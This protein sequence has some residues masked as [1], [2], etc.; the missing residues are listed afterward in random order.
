MSEKA[1]R[2][3]EISRKYGDPWIWGIYITLV[4]L[5]IV[6]SYSAS[7]RE[8]AQHGIYEP[9]IKQVVFLGIGAS[10][11]AVLHRIN[12][13]NKLVMLVLIPLLWIFTVGSL[14]YVMVAGD[15]INGARRSFTIMGQ[16]VQPA[17]LA[18]LSAVTMLAYVMARNQRKMDVTNTGVIISAAVAAI[19]GGLTYVSGATNAIIIMS[20]SL[21]MMVVGGCTLKKLGIVL[22]VYGMVFGAYKLIGNANEQREANLAQ[23]RIEA[24]ASTTTADNGT[25]ERVVDRG[26]MREGRLEN[27][28]KHD[29]LLYKPITPYNQQEMFSMMAQAHGGILGTGIGN[30]RE[31]S[32][33]P[34]A[35]S[36]YIFSIIIEEM[37]LVG[38]IFVMILYLWLLARAAMIAR[39]CHRV[40]PALLIIGM[41]SMITFQ[42]L[43][44]MAINTGVFP[45]SGQPLPLVSKG[46][47]SIIVTSIAFGVMFSVSRTIANTGNKKNKNEDSEEELQTMGLDA[48]NP[49]EILPKNEWK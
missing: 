12:Y 15:F 20:I 23:S 25:D 11:I 32:R 3:Q 39:R 44:H 7:S 36:D 1:T 35:F 9:L 5:S 45:V 43:C 46:G 29:S 8:I 47:T 31:C 14:G 13:N 16:S 34:L 48:E 49:I 4:I 17:E 38:G 6:E 21:T 42:A 26:K 27:W 22:V 40:L 18:K 2:Y 41:A 24:A 28:R 19:F 30:S 37:G 33:L 10:C